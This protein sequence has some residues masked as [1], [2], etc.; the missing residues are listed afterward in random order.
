MI[1][2][3]AFMSI[4]S[5][6]TGALRIRLKMAEEKVKAFESGEKYVRMQEQ[7]KATFREQNARIHKLEYDL[8]RA[9]AQTV[10]VREKWSEIFDDV[11]REANA[12][13]FALRREIA[14]LERRVL[15]VERQRDAAKDRLRDELRDKNHEI[16]ELKAALY[17]AEQKIAALTA[18]INKDYTNSSKSSSQSPDHKTIPNGR[19]KSGRK[20][21]GQ[22]G[23]I[24]H[25]RKHMEPTEVIAIPAPSIYKDG[26]NFK[27][28]GNTV[29]KQLAKLHVGV[30]VVECNTPEF[31]N[32]TTDQR[33]HAAFPEGLKDEVTYD[34]AVKAFTYLLNN[35]CYVSIV[36]TQNFI[37][38][39]T[40]GNLNLSTGLI[41]NLSKEFSEQTKEERDEIFLKLFCAP[42][43]HADFT[44]GRMNG[45]QASVM[46]CAAGDTVLYQ[47]RPKKGDEGVAGSPL[48][49]YEGI[50]VSDHEASLIKHGSKNQEC[51]AHIKRY[52]M[53]SI[54][55]EK[56][57]TWNVMM[58]EWIRDALSHW[59]DVRDGGKE[60]AEKVSGLERRYDEIMEK[61]RGEYEYEPPSEYF[62]DGYNLYKRMSEEKERY[63]LFL[64]DTTVEPYNNLA[65]RCARKFKRKAA[66]AMCF[67]SQDGVERFCDGLS[68]TQSIKASGGNLYESVTERFNMGLEV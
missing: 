44:F 19:E 27:E 29:R 67:R 26:P 17:D 2:Q 22:K 64:N 23:H 35:E 46:I 11:Y 37:K 42:V 56:G 24:H 28:T 4:G 45:S 55:N 39:V 21:G 38:E 49:F 31:R 20:P 33:V 1:D 3:E 14:R 40:G 61:A 68:I 5:F 66:Q 15:E 53:G 32:Q 63:T 54:E 58:K 60:S 13:K 47:G 48:E 16:Y 36:K 18:R 7:F 57:L 50:L 10:S 25:E 52:V 59:K 12:G 30:E 34:G 62:K 8:G 6:D 65:E 9:H 41:C 51:M 43:L